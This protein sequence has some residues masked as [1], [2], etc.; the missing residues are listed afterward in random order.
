M[1]LSAP[2]ATARSKVYSITARSVSHA[3][4]NNAFSKA[5]RGGLV[6]RTVCGTPSEL[7]PDGPGAHG[8]LRS[9]SESSQQ[10]HITGRWLESGERAQQLQLPA[11]VAQSE[12]ELSTCI[13]PF[14]G[15][16][17]SIKNELKV[18][19]HHGRGGWRGLGGGGSHR[20]ASF[21]TS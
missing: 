13:R 1:P 12:K 3:S 11:C 14:A 19:S 9:S 17:F 10:Q 7:R 18:Y 16:T 8:S 2:M 6:V 21:V 15:G 20:C 4:G 5:R